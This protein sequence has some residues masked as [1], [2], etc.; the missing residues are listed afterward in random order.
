MQ[1]NR[2]HRSL[3]HWL[4]PGMTVVLVTVCTIFAAGFAGGAD[5]P[6]ERNSWAEYG[7]GPDNSHYFA[8]TQ[9]T[10]SNV[11][12]LQ[13]AW[14]YPTRDMTTYQLNPLVVDNVMYVLARNTS[15]VALDATTG[16]ELWVHESLFGIARR[17]INY[18]ESKDR[19]DR[20]LVFQINNTLQEL[21]ARTGKS[22]VVNFGTDGF[23]DLRKGLGRDP[24]TV[25]HIS[26]ATA[27]K[28][29]ENLIILGSAPGEGYMG[30]PGDLRAYNV[31]TGALV[32]Q[33]HT[34][35][36]PG[37]YGYETWP[38]DAWKYI[39]GVNTWGELS[40]D[41]KRGIAYF[42]TGSA[43]S[44]F[45]GADRHGTDLFANCLIALDARTGKRLWH[46]QGVHHDLWDYDFTAA[47]QL[48]TVTQNGKKI[49]AVAEA[50]KQGFL[51]VF[52][53]VT[54]KPLWPI[55]ERP[56]P[57][58]TDVPGE[59]VWPTQPFPT[60]PPPFARQKFAVD[61]IN[62]YFLTPEE[63][64][65]WKEIISKADNGGLFTPPAFKRVTVNMPGDRGGSIWGMT[66]SDPAKGL[67]YVASIDTPFLTKLDEKLP[68]GPTVAVGAGNDGS[69]LSVYQHSCQGCHGADRD[70]NGSVPSLRYVVSRIGPGG[71]TDAVRNGRGEMPA[72]GVSM[73]A[74]DLNALIAYL[75]NADG[76]PARGGRGG[77]AYAGTGPV[78]GG[79][80]VASGGAPAAQEFFKRMPTS[81]P[82]YGAQGGPPYPPGLD[83]PPQRYYTGFD[84]H[85][86]I[87]S[88]PW[89]RLT[90]YDLNTGTVKWWI[91]YG[92][93]PRA[94]AE[95]IR[96]TGIMHDQRA[97][98]V[99]STGLLIGATTDG[100][101][102]AYDADTG[103]ILWTSQLPAASN[104]IPAM[105]EVKGKTYIVVVAAASRVS[106]GIPSTLKLIDGGSGQP[107]AYV[108]YA[109][110]GK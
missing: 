13:V 68:S 76:A 24:D 19:K 59:E 93:E 16:K 107:R 1:A 21:D 40:V 14:T 6:K 67:M 9:I 103:T 48:I 58:K 29:F 17:G 86:E 33:F 71:V 88:P 18:W 49:D 32:W 89:S 26:S 53:R 31:I 99:T 23:V 51:Y 27:G 78:T 37:E 11:S 108:A 70:G 81:P 15:L 54:G 25:Y 82:E 46:F 52:D 42:P 87:I 106:F 8:G 110:P 74:A 64:A 4:S 109:L 56:V 50:S 104:A 96:N 22:I 7:G 95:G 2:T 34:V 61:D 44:D 47:P 80:V 102:R 65:S 92:E 72:I 100:Y 10:K 73:S 83:V 94:V 97:V 55:E 36:H 43:S 20:R 60:A 39:G 35:P 45:Y 90:A 84:A 12:K 98:L 63:R 57:T 77:S 101:V 85:R 38:K 3:A 62:P 41:E 66:S 28:V 30:A 69:G 105:Y 5:A 79:P 75:D 91:P